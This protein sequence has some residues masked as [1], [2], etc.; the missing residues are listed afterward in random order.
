MAKNQK[1]VSL[2]WDAFQSMGNPENAPDLVDEEQEEEKID[3]STHVVRLYKERKNRGGK[4]VIIIKGIEE[5]DEFLTDLTKELKKKCGVGGS[6]KNGEIII[7]GDNRKK[8]QEIL[9]AKGYSNT[10][11]AGT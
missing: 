10:K 4:I 9:L 7:Q 11:L 6:V 2:S 1:P 8:V 5:S 3:P